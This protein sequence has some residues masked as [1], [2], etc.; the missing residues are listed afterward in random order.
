LKEGDQPELPSN[1]RLLKERQHY[2]MV[3]LS[4]AQFGQNDDRFGQDASRK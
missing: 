4:A 1:S 2:L 3:A